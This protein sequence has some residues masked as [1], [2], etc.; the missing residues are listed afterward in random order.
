MENGGFGLGTQVA[1]EMLT[2]MLDELPDE[3]K[4]PSQRNRCSDYLKKFGWGEGGEI[5]VDVR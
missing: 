4:H 5:G 1:A 3:S 2:G